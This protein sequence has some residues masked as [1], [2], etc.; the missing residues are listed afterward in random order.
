MTN[1]LA[2]PRRLQHAENPAPL[3]E[4]RDLLRLALRQAAAAY[5]GCKGR[6]D[7]ADDLQRLPQPLARGDR[8]PLSR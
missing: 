7:E 8:A 5:D 4:R 6:L 1:A 2:L 3:A